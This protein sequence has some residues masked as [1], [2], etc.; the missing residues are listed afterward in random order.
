MHSRPE[1][2]IALASLSGFSSK[3]LSGGVFK[4]RTLGPNLGGLCLRC[5]RR[6]AHQGVPSIAQYYYWVY[7]FYLHST[8]FSL[9]LGPSV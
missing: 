7:G 1:A 6:N 3:L 8:G 5:W 9:V 2:H 4:E